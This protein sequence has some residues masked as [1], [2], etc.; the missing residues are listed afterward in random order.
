MTVNMITICDKKIQSDDNN[1][2]NSILDSSAVSRSS[3]RRKYVYVPNQTVLDEFKE[4]GYDCLNCAEYLMSVYAGMEIDK[5]DVNSRIVGTTSEIGNTNPGNAKAVNEYGEVIDHAVDPEVGQA[6]FICRTNPESVPSDDAAFYHAAFVIAKSV[7]CNFT[8]ETF[9]RNDW[10]F[11][12]YK[13]PPLKV[14]TFYDF[15][16]NQSCFKGA[17][18]KTVAIEL[19]R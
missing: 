3:T 10:Y 19:D 4:L 5:G 6:Y 9:H 15:W 18:V 2:A 16:V 14:G 13:R 7:D 12:S 1:I 11:R 8:L 17:N